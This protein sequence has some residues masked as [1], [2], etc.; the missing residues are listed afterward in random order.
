MSNGNVKGK[1]LQGKN[2]M[3]LIFRRTNIYRKPR[4][5]KFQRSTKPSSGKNLYKRNQNGIREKP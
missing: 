5:L 1:S 4:R 3:R 2:K